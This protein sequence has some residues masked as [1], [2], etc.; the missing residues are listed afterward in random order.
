MLCTAWL[1]SRNPESALV[2]DVAFFVLYGTDWSTLTHVA[3]IVLELYG[4]DRST[5]RDGALFALC[6]SDKSLNGIDRSTL[7]DVA[8]FVLGL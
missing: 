2:R 6:V 5:L 8:F 4:K 7:R 3:V 1:P